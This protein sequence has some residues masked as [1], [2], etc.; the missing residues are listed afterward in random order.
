MSEDIMPEVGTMKEI[1]LKFANLALQRE[2]ATL[3]A[4]IK[5]AP[6]LVVYK[7]VNPGE[8]GPTIPSFQESEVGKL[9]LKPGEFGVFALI[10]LPGGDE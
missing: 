5:Q 3:K 10:K 9:D 7:M 4:S 2:L 8:F 6:R 1:E